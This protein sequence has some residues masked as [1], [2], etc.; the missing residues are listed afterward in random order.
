MDGLDLCINGKLNANE[1]MNIY[2][3][4]VQRLVRKPPLYNS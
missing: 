2:V 1:L 3:A 4:F